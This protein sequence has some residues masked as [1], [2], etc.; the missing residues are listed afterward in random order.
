MKSPDTTGIRI[1]WQAVTQETET[2]LAMFTTN[3]VI[4]RI[5]AVFHPGE[6]FNGR[7]ELLVLASTS[8]HVRI[9]QPQLPQAKVGR[10][11]KLRFRLTERQSQQSPQVEFVMCRKSL[12]T[13]DFNVRRLSPSLRIRILK[14]SAMQQSGLQ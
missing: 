4:E 11:M 3:R 9:H 7:C 13:R 8:A 5:A 2:H 12:R 6:S 10:C 14:R 1:Q